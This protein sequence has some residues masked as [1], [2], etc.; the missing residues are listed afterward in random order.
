M[1]PFPSIPPNPIEIKEKTWLMV[2]KCSFCGLGFDPIWAT[3]LTS[4]KHFYHDWCAL[5]HFNTSFFCIENKCGQE[6][7]DAWNVVGLRKLGTTISMMATLPKIE[8]TVIMKTRL[9]RLS[10]QKIGA[11]TNSLNLCFPYF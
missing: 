6:M 11:C 10:I 3:R 4:C 5:S 9:P 2:E 1:H 7:H 8:R